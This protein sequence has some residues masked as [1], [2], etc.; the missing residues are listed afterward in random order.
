M[1]PL[2]TKKRMTFN[3]LA[4]KNTNIQNRRRSMIPNLSQKKPKAKGLSKKNKELIRKAFIQVRVLN[5]L[6][7]PKK[8]KTKMKKSLMKLGL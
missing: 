8:T 6:R 7:K 5:Y 1:E 3:T 4:I 2:E